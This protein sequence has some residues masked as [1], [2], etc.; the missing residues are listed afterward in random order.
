MGRA[1]DEGVW[2]GR[3]FRAGRH[4]GYMPWSPGARAGVRGAA[5]GLEPPPRTIEIGPNLDVQVW[6]FMIVSV[7]E[8]GF[9]W[10]CDRGREY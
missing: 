8:A 1:H 6:K 7:L 9:L 2:L 5:P 4:A 3:M 10:R